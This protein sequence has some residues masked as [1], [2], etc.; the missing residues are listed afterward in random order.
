MLTTLLQRMGLVLYSQWP[1]GAEEE[2][3]GRLCVITGGR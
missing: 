1:A 2:A 3:V